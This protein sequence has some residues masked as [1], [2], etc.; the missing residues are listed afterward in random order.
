MM[1]EKVKRQTQ[2]NMEAETMQTTLIEDE[3]L[4]SK[5]NKY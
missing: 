5:S 3:A 2:E 1:T 4:P